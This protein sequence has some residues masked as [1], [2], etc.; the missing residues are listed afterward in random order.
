MPLTNFGVLEPRIP[1]DSAGPFIGRCAMPDEHGF[2]VIRTMGY[3][4]IAKLC[5]EDEFPV[6][7]EA[8]LFRATD[9]RQVIQFPNLSPLNPDTKEMRRIAEEI[10]RL[11]AAGAKVL[12]HCMKGRDRS[13]LVA[14]PIRLIKDKWTLEQ[15]LEEF[16]LYGKAIAP[17]HH[18]YVQAIKKLDAELRA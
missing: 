15:A 5:T 8:R 13:G 6:R 12:M 18:F 4:V 11:D 17:I 9:G 14:A 1:I 7:E 2:G 16:D 10:I 3:D